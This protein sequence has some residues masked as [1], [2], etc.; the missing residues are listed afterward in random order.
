MRR[1]HKRGHDVKAAEKAE[2]R[3]LHR[4]AYQKFD[5]SNMLICAHYAERHGLG[6]FYKTIRVYWPDSFRR[7]AKNARAWAAML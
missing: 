4:I 7:Y 1:N 3:R 2:V 6:A 5:V